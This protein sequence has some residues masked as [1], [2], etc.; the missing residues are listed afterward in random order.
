MKRIIL[1]FEVHQPF[2]IRKDFFWNPRFRQNLEDRFFDTER[3]RE[4]FER[5]K[6]NCYIPATSIILNS[7]ERAEE[8]GREIK[9]FF[10]ISGT[11]LEQAERWGKEVIELFQQLSYTHKVEFLAQTYYHSVTGLWE[12]KSEW[13]EQVK[14]HKEAIRT[15]FD[16]NPTTFENTELITNKEIVEEAEKM[17]F[18]MILSEGTERNLKGRSPNYVYKLKQHE[19]RILFRNYRLSDDIAFRFSNPQWDQ[20]PLTAS[21]YADWISASEGNVGL[22]FIDYETFG[23]HHKEHTGILEFLR[24][25]PIELSKREVEMV[26]PKDVYNDVYH[27]IDIDHTT[28]WADIEKDEKSWL[29]NIM[30]WAYDDAVRRGE[31]PSKE[32]G[33]EYLKVWRYFTTSDNYYYLFLGSGGPAEVHSYFNAFGSPI[34]AFI[35]EFYAITAFIHE[36]LQKLSIKNEPYIF[37]LGNKRA[38]IAWN[39]KEF[40]EVVMRDERFKAHLKNL[41]LWLGNE[42]D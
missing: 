19:I 33:N 7:I 14:M 9:Y 15:Y 35:N 40:M 17:G 18:K 16:Q 30:Q 1:G 6:K 37:T 32:L 2:R 23:E 5:I 26:T 38:S 10:S 20:Y 28:S 41:R 42:K 31:M 11:F 39:E 29:G 13:K 24:W 36:E 12:D 22:I 3:N 21:K 8:E 34:D 27:E 25:L 4:I